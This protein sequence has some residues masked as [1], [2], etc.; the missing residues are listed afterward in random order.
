MNEKQLDEGLRQLAGDGSFPVEITD[1]LVDS[2]LA[3]EFEELSDDLKENFV[4]K[5]RVRIQD[6]AIKKACQAV[7]GKVIPFGRFIEEIREK[8]E[9]TRAEVATRLGKGED[10]VQ[11]VERGDLSPTCLPRADAAD[12]VLLFQIK[13]KNVAQMVNASL[14]TATT[15]QMFRSAA[16][17]SHGGIRHDQR[18]EDVEKAIDAFAGRLRQKGVTRQSREGVDVEAFLIGLR[19]EIARRGRVDLLT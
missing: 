2:F 4:S 19:E 12:L 6:A 13:M 8:A 5:L 14:E 16:A 7:G 3:R 15:K 17:R 11:R 9:L 18:S 1:E 10:F